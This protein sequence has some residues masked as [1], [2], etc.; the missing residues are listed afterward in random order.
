MDS[1]QE[2][3]KEEQFEKMLAIPDDLGKICNQL[4]RLMSSSAKASARFQSED[5]RLLE[6]IEM[7]SQQYSKPT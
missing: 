5:R 7:F 4:I 2:Q 3:Y 6:A 1:S